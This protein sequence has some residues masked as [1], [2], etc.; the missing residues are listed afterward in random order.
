MR[1]TLTTG[2]FWLLNHPYWGS[3]PLK[4]TSLGGRGSLR[5]TCTLLLP[6]DYSGLTSRGWFPWRWHMLR[7]A[8]SDVL[9]KEN[10]P[11]QLSLLAGVD[12]KS[13]SCSSYRRYYYK[14]CLHIWLY[15]PRFVTWWSW[16]VRIAWLL[17]RL[18]IVKKPTIYVNIIQG[19]PKRAL[20]LWKL[21]EIYRGHTQRFELSK[22]SK[23]H[24]VLPRIVIP[25]LR[26]LHRHLYA[27]VQSAIPQA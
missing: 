14:H 25:S 1:N 12:P 17:L 19:V 5:P 21:I 15:S 3:K 18:W 6:V 2:G 13:M 20:Q 24:R 4:Y 16:T 11:L 9:F 10:F 26:Y 8:Y 7:S 22:C 27:N 23:T